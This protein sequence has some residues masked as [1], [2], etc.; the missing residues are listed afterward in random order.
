MSHA[1]V[2]LMGQ[3]EAASVLLMGRGVQGRFGVW[4]VGQGARAVA[5]AHSVGGQIPLV[6]GHSRRRAAILVKHRCGV[7]VEAGAGGGVCMGGEVRVGVG[8]CGV[9]RLIVGV[10]VGVGEGVALEV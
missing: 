4:R 1:L 6:G 2:G 8:V 9:V 10:R 5:C 3:R 7:G